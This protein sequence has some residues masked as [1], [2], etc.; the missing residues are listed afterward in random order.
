MNDCFLVDHVIMR[1][2]VGALQEVEIFVSVVRAGSFTAAGREL[3]LPK[4]SVSRK[5]SSLEA[6]LGSRLLHR[7]T[8]SLNLTEAGQ[9]YFE[10]ASRIIDELDDLD[11]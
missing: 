3:D 1:S 6:R 9:I 11:L 2:T 5:V 8:R 10:Q 4:S 7:T